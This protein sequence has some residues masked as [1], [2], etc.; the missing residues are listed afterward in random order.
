MRERKRAYNMEH[1]ED[2]LAYQ[3]EYYE[4]N[5]E[6]HRAYSLE[7]HRNLHEMWDGS[8]DE[9]DIKIE[10]A[11]NES[12]SRYPYKL[13]QRDIAD[14]LGVARS[15]VRDR[16]VKM[17]IDTS[18]EAAQEELDRK[19]INIIETYKLKGTERPSMQTIADQTGVCVSTV[20]NRMVSMGID[21]AKKHRASNKKDQRA[22]ERWA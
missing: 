20:R 15:T 9:L 22:R 21:T 17:G 8:K 3:R 11:I 19:I 5:K 6:E 4:R 1:A 16:M 14:Q 2:R 18:R 12:V 13:S 7:R 10:E